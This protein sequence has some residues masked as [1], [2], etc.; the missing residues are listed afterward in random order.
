MYGVLDFDFDLDLECGISRASRGGYAWADVAQ[1]ISYSSLTL[2]V[3]SAPDLKKHYLVET[4]LISPG[5]WSMDLPT[6]DVRSIQFW[7]ATARRKR[8]QL[9]GNSRDPFIFL[10]GFTQ[11]TG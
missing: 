11:A 10:R 6:C 5:S 2:Q 4:N 3:V 1:N 9:A 7:G 8:I